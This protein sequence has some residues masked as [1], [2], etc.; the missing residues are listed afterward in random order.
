[1]GDPMKA[2]RFHGPDKALTPAELPIPEPAQDEVLIQIKAAGLCHT[3][4]GIMR[5]PGWLPRLA[6]RPF[7]LGHE[8]AGIVTEVGSA[9]SGVRVGDRVG[10]SPAGRTRPGLGR[11]GGYGEWCTAYPEDLIPIPSNVTFVQAAAGVDAGKTAW[12]SVVC[13][14]QVKRGERLLVIGLGGIGQV[15]ARLAVLRGA[16]VTVVEP[17][18]NV[19]SMSEGLGVTRVVQ[20]ADELQGEDFDVVIDFAGKGDT[21]R[22]AVLAVRSQGRVVQVGLSALEVQVSM[23]DLVTR[24]VSLIGSSG[25]STEDIAEIYALMSSGELAPLLP[26]ITFEEIPEGLGRVERGEVMGRLVAEY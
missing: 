11:D 14:G 23:H 9:A 6:P 8:V 10:I 26:T 15:A 20:G 5:D 13:R 1:M 25:G 7:T 2:W 24:Q 17:R 21:T 12:H 16:E 18:R 19:W 4:V 3:D 22:Q